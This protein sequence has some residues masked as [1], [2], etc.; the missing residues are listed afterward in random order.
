M[1]PHDQIIRDKMEGVLTP[2]AI[3]KIMNNPRIT[4]RELVDFVVM[5]D[6]FT[7]D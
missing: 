1:N 6:A 4:G 3:E 2:Q 5:L 7:R